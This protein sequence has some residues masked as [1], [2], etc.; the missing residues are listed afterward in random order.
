MIDNDDPFEE[1]IQ[2]IEY[3][4]KYHKCSSCSYIDED[5][6]TCY[7]IIYQVMKAQKQIENINL[8]NGKSFNCTKTSFFYCRW[9]VDKSTIIQPV[10][11]TIH[12]DFQTFIDVAFSVQH[13]EKILDFYKISQS[14]YTIKGNKEHFNT[15]QNMINIFHYKFIDLYGLSFSYSSYENKIKCYMN[16]KTYPENISNYNNYRLLPKDPTKFNIISSESRDTFWKDILMFYIGET[17]KDIFISGIC[18]I[19]K[20][21]S[22]LLLKDFFKKFNQNLPIYFSC[23][24]LEQN[25]SNI[26][27]LIQI[28]LNELLIIY[29]DEQ[30]NIN[31]VKTV[32]TKF[33]TYTRCESFWVLIQDLINILNETQTKHL[34][35]LDQYKMSFDSENIGL[36]NILKL[37]KENKYVQLIVCSSMNNSDI[38]EV[39]KP[40]FNL[41]SQSKLHFSSYYYFTKLISCQGMESLEKLNDFEM[42][43]IND[44][45]YIPKYSL[46]M[47]EAKREDD[48]TVQSKYNK[49]R[50]NIIKKI[51]VFNDNS[52]EK[53]LVSILKLNEVLDV[54]ISHHT[55]KE[56]YP[57]IHMKYFEISKLNN[58]TYL[59]EPIFPLVKKIIVE[60]SYSFY[61]NYQKNQIILQT[62]A[63]HGNVI[64]TLFE[65][66][67]HYYITE[68]VCFENINNI[69]KVKVNDIIKLTIQNEESNKI[70]SDVID[71]QEYTLYFLPK[72]QNAKHYD[73]A[74]LR[75]T[76]VSTILY[77]LQITIHKDN[78]KI[79]QIYKDFPQEKKAIRDNINALLHI[80]LPLDNIVLFFIIPQSSSSNTLE[81]LINN[82]ANIICFNEETHLFFLKKKEKDELNNFILR[83]SQI[84]QLPT[85]LE[86]LDNLYVDNFN[87]I[88]YK[89]SFTSVPHFFTLIDS[90]NTFLNKKIK[91]NELDSLVTLENHL[92]SKELDL[93]YTAY[94]QLKNKTLYL[95]YHIKGA[96]IPLLEILK[97]KYLII[98]YSINKGKYAFNSELGNPVH[99]LVDLANSKILDN[100]QSYSQ[101]IT[102][103]LLNLELDSIDL[104]G[105]K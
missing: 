23:K 71:K 37:I 54:E 70:I 40:Y 7:C 51:N 22:L 64:G 99:K 83:D 33:I 81:P 60:I 86:L 98:I 13:L 18:G 65:Q 44:V 42:S 43:L 34:L 53:L 55:L 16:S 21:V 95:F 31:L 59:I 48:Q 94:P 9:D 49:I 82:N 72:N 39:I 6:K 75:K 69:S 68:E 46:K 58:G 20:T 102:Q 47:L 91:R 14:Y 3:I 89:H 30:K 77:L 57:Y 73:S 28:M 67:I 24:L 100:I 19:G 96:K 17:S 35:I 26:V 5:S 38:K 88:T 29:P 45:N 74:I 104:F 85:E 2:L 50:K 11:I 93:I 80:N 10:C 105:I 76:K 79:N 1:N 25:Q 97:K 41:V 66:T 12:L 52:E 87:T 78:D 27:R 36:S 32:Y 103:L 63:K 84:N 15:S 61:K 90:K 56:I 4:K 92:P 101:I 8:I 62:S